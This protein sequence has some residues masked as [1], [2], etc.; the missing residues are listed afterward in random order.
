M[1]CRSATIAES[2]SNKWLRSRRR[3][4]ICWTGNRHSAE[5]LRLWTLLFRDDGGGRWR[6]GRGGSSRLGGRVIMAR[7]VGCLARI[8]VSRHSDPRAVWTDSV[9]R[10]FHWVR[11]HSPRRDPL[12]RGWPPQAS[13]TG[14][15]PTNAPSVHSSAEAGHPKVFGGFRLDA[16]GRGR[17]HGPARHSGSGAELDAPQQPRWHN[18]PR[19][20]GPR[21]PAVVA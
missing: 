6:C 1:T 20:S 13:R 5:T 12:E 18:A 15:S 14:W 16:G 19:T 10:G 4:G 21:C 8:C 11:S 9:I 3:V 17:E 7:H 2:N